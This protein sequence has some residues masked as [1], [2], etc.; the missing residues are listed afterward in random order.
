MFESLLPRDK[1][2]KR[3]IPTRVDGTGIVQ[4]ATAPMLP[5]VCLGLALAFALAAALSDVTWPLCL[6]ARVLAQVEMTAHVCQ[7]V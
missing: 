6:R 7:D 5:T 3:T 4:G 2:I 1:I